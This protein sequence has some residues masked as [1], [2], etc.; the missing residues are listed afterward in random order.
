MLFIGIIQSILFLGHWFL[1]V[2]WNRFLGSS[3][4]SG[5]M[6]TGLALLSLSFVL[7]SLVAWYSHHAVVR[8][9]Y[10][11][12]AVWLG[13]ASYFFWASV[14]CWLAYGMARM[15]A[16]P[17][18][19]HSIFIVLFV[20]AMLTGICGIVNA[21]WLRV[22]R[23]NVSL[24]HLPEQWRGR[25]AAL[26]SDTHLGHIRNGRFIRRVVRKLAG[27]KPD[28]VFLAGDIYDG[29]AADFV[30][31]AQPWKDLTCR[32]EGS[33]TAVPLGV[34]Y[35][36]GNHEEFYSDAEYH[37]PLVAAGVHE[38][39]NQKVEVDGLQL[40]GVHYR[41]AAHPERYRQI[42]RQAV[43]DPNRASILLLH[44][45]VHLEE[46]EQAGIS[47]QLSGHTHGGQF[48]PYTWITDRVWG[49]F[50]HGLQRAGNLMVYTNYG[51]GTWG[52]PM[53]VGTFPEIVLIQFE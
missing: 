25:K 5:T 27:L 39:N 45:P 32:R 37:D 44:A 15:A 31:L 23:I 51:A 22:T 52:P 13:F 14:L 38:L 10:T 42:L 18:E 11:L 3:A 17:W 30:K 29:A 9:F 41:D 33:D 53:R 20:M 35:I 19:K 47:L 12:A 48:L 6:K 8:F 46:A 7:T 40:V 43:L 28:I 21:A 1:Y 49:K 2:T 4:S 16:L 50:V 34:Y 26:V 36:A 24:P